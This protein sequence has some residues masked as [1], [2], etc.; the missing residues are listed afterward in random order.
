MILLDHKSISR[1]LA[2]LY[3]IHSNFLNPEEKY[4]NVFDH[5]FF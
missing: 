5:I 3:S 4:F 2:N 1:V